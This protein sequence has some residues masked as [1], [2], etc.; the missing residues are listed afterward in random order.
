MLVWWHRLAVLVV[1]SILLL[2]S[3]LTLKFLLE[4]VVVLRILLLHQSDLTVFELVRFE[5]SF[6]L[7]WGQL[8]TER[9]FVTELSAIVTYWWALWHFFT[10]IGGGRELE[11]RMH[12]FARLRFRTEASQI[13]LAQDSSDVPMTTTWAMPA[14]ASIV[15]RTILD[16]ALG[17][18]VKKR[19]L[20]LV[21]GVESRIEI[22]L[23]HFRHIVLVQK[24]AAVALL[25]QRPQPML[26]HDCLLFSFD[27]PERA[28]LFVAAA[29]NQTLMKNCKFV[30][31]FSTY[32]S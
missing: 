14:K 10:K 6:A 18:Y 23:R 5:L 31:I 7:L 27:V 3:Q 15:P 24:F 32:P 25:A 1:P 13:V 29:Y 17:V 20:F 2:L 12:V 26:A 11:A 8:R 30:Y 28:E 22:A 19:A 4:M 16:L 9:S 21:A